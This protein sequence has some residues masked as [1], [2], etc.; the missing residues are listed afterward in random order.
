MSNTNNE[1][2][3][4]HSHCQSQFS[5]KY[6]LVLPLPY[7]S[8]YTFTNKTFNR[9][10]LLLH[11]KKWGKFWLNRQRAF[12]F[13]FQWVCSL[14]VKCRALIWANTF[15][16]M[17][18]RKMNGPKWEGCNMRLDVTE[19]WGVL[20]QSNYICLLAV[21]I[22]NCSHKSLNPYPA[23]VENMVSF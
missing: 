1:Y 8:I 23:N 2:L 20:L 16:I 11:F 18:I 4:A 22:N 19:Y 3:A 5:T 15:E 17:V 9:K 10:A 21:A 6:D 13:S 12:P 14:A 7:Y